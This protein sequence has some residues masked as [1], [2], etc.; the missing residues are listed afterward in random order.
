V[1]IGDTAH[2]YELS[3]S[4]A[5]LTAGGG[6]VNAIDLIGAPLPLRSG[7]SVAVE[8]KSDFVVSNAVSVGLTMC[9]QGGTGAAGRCYYQEFPLTIG[10]SSAQPS[11]A[12]TLT[13]ELDAGAP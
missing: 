7:R 10:S 9:V 1:Y 4:T 8:F 11:D 13:R 2:A 5:L 3:P 12:S 6:N